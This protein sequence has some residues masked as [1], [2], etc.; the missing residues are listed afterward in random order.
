M[1]RRRTN[2][3]RVALELLD[4]ALGLR[5][6]SAKFICEKGTWRRGGEKPKYC[7]TFERFRRPS[8]TAKPRDVSF[9]N[10]MLLRGHR[11]HT[12]GFLSVCPRPDLP[13]VRTN[14]EINGLS[15]L[16]RGSDL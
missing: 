3:R 13:L 2:A 15:S 1:V 6:P 11:S 4:K 7:G 12:I 9:E 8:M 16:A 5:V 10:Q 14:I